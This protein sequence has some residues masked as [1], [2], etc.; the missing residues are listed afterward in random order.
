RNRG[1]LTF[2]EVGARWGFATV[3]I[4]Q[5]MALADLDNDGDLDVVMNN[6]NSGAGVYRND[7]SAPRIAVRLKG[8]PPNTQGIGGKI[9]VT[10]GPVAQSQEIICGGRYLSGD[11]PMRVFA[12]GS[13][14]NK[15]TI[16]VG[17]RSGKRSVVR[18]ATPNRIY[19]IDEA[20]ASSLSTTGGEGQG[21][22]A[23]SKSEIAKPLFEDVTSALRG[24]IH[25]EEPFDDFERQPLLPNRLSQLGPG[26]A[27]HDL[28]GDGWDDLFITSGRGG[29]LAIFKNNGQGGFQP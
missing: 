27:W 26:I 16:T 24:H 21:E 3:G 18:D 14:T 20:S 2:E 28:D 10:G 9:T 15:L 23:K 17:W 29:K 4:S 22:E 25:Q 6:L 19:E 1:D 5:G 13:L 11:D 7:T 8:I 12:A